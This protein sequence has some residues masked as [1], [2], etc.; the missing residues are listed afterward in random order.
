LAE[1]KID[2][3]RFRIIPGDWGKVRSGWL[4]WLLLNRAARH[5]SGGRI[6]QF[7]WRYSRTVK[8]R[9]RDLAARSEIRNHF[10]LN[11]VI[12]EGFGSG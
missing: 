7:L 2:V 1:S 5:G 12:R 11:Q 8:M 3:D 4:T 6:H 10:E 9:M